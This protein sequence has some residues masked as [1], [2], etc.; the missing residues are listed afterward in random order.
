MTWGQYIG[1]KFKLESTLSCSDTLRRRT[2]ISVLL[3][4]LKE[5]GASAILNRSASRAYAYSTSRILNTEAP[6]PV[7]SRAFFLARCSDMNYRVGGALP[8]D[9]KSQRAIV[10]EKT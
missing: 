3:N 7:A 8:S 2:V 5:S 4:A 9:Y 1:S 6:Q 10:G